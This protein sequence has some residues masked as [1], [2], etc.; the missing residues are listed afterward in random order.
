MPF[1]K[2]AVGDRC[3]LSPCSQEDAER[4]TAWE[5]DLDIAVP[6]G[7]EAYT[8]TSIDQQ[9]ERLREAA[10]R[11]EH[12]FDIVRLDTDR[13]IG[14]CML[15]AL[16]HVNRH[17]MLGILLDGEHQ[18]QGYGR[19]AIRLLLDYGF[20]LL[21][22]NGVML[23]VMAFNEGAIRCYKAV[24]FREIGRRRQARIIAG[25]KHDVILMDILAEEYEPL[26]LTR[27]LPGEHA[28]GKG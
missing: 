1:V 16:D 19:E 22:L 12:V 24:G 9:R 20:C 27:H 21:N 14:R 5:N 17:A 23:G 3:Y 2:R 28:L 11:H 13:A 18:G 25:V 10:A 7:G 8:T 26:F 4:W 15:F 6:L